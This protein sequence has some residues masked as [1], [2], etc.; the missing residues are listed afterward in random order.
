M[1]ADTLVIIIGASL[2]ATITIR[3]AWRHARQDL[4]FDRGLWFR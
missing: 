1:T 4:F 2:A 3:T